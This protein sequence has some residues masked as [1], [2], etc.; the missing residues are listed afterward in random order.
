M[1]NETGGVISLTHSGRVFAV[2][3][4]R[5]HSLADSPPLLELMPG[6][7]FT[8]AI[9][10]F[11]NQLDLMVDKREGTSRSFSSPGAPMPEFQRPDRIFGEVRRREWHN[12]GPSPQ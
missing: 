10:R 4:R 6:R 2:Y 1:E 8:P 9:L 3:I 7:S 11:A 5:A 12:L